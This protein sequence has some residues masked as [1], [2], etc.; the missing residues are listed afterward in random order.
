MHLKGK[1]NK[2]AQ[3][4]TS[5]WHALSDLFQRAFTPF[6]PLVSAKY[7]GHT[8]LWVLQYITKDFSTNRNSIKKLLHAT[9][10]NDERNWK[11]ITNSKF[12]QK[13]K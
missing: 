10:Y 2:K 7:N 12:G 13:N 3:I 5:T 1:H 4:R 8:V 6:S 11:C 9:I